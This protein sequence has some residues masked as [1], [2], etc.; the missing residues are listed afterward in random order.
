MRDILQIELL[1]TVAYRGRR[2][3]VSGTG[4]IPG[5]FIDYE[6]VTWRRGVADMVDTVRIKH[7]S[8][9]TSLLGFKSYQQGRKSFQ[10]TA[11][12]IIHLDEEPP[13]DVHTESLT[14]LAT[15]KGCQILTFTPLNGLTEVAMSF[16][17]Q[18]MRPSEV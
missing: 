11:Q 1:G 5:E 7:V 10:G 3:T 6:S 15:T 13:Q 4:M 9:K 8:G 17:P 12:D 2:K 18:E 16:M 14:R